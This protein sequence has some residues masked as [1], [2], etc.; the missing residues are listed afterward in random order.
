MTAAGFEHKW[1]RG[2]ALSFRTAGNG[3][4]RFT[5]LRSDTLGTGYDLE[6][7]RNIIEGRAALPDGRARSAAPTGKQKIN[8]IVDIQKKISEGKGAGYEK[9]AKLY[10]LK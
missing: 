6:D 3:Q 8:L 10:N 7:I 2:G 1:V 4:E 5:R 9:W